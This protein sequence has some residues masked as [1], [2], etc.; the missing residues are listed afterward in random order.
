MGSVSVWEGMRDMAVAIGL[1][2][3]VLDHAPRAV[4]G[5]AGIAY[6]PY[7]NGIV[8][9]HADAANVALGFTA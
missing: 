1:M 2:R 4:C 6:R 5:T 8:V 9:A 3:P 7:P